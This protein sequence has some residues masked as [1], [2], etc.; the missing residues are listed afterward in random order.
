[1][2]K[3]ILVVDDEPLILTTIEKALVKVGFFVAKAQNM[4]ELDNALGNAPFDLLI[5]DIY[6]EDI[7]A[8][9]IIDRVKQKSP[10]VKIVKMSGSAVRTKSDDF[11]EKPFRID[12][13]RKKVREILDVPARD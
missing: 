13:L 6:M 5:T 4:N 3:R 10:E 11:V 9:E 12:D 8:D 1:M 7:T 2:S